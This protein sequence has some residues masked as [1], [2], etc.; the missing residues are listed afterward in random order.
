M[1]YEDAYLDQEDTSKHELVASR[2]ELSHFA[3][4]PDLLRRVLP[5]VCDN[6]RCLA[7]KT[8]PYTP[9]WTIQKLRRASIVSQEWYDFLRRLCRMPGANKYGLPGLKMRAGL[10]ES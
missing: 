3:K 6:I 5:T 7:S 9:G 4:D 2:L 1:R 8:N 10:L